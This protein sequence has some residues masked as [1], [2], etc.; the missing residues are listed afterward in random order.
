MKPAYF[1]L[2]REVTCTYVKAL[3]NVVNDLKYAKTNPLS[4]LLSYKSEEIDGAEDITDSVK[5]LNKIY[6]ILIK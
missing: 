6:L 3:R 1:S 2:I 4:K 5:K